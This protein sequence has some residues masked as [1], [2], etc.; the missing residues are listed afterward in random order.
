VAFDERHEGGDAI[1]HRTLLRRRDHVQQ[2]LAVTLPAYHLHEFA[3]G[4]GQPLLHRARIGL[5]GLGERGDLV[6]HVLA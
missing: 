6:V 5:G 4:R 1:D 3:D 2:T